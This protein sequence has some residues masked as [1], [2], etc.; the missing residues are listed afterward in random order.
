MKIKVEKNYLLKHLKMVGKALP[1]KTPLQ[2]LEGIL[3]ELTDEQLQLKASDSNLTIEVKVPFEKDGERKIEVESTGGF[4]VTGKKMIEIISKAKDGFITLELTEKGLK[5]QS[6]RSRSILPVFPSSDYPHISVSDVSTTY[7]IHSNEL[8]EII[9]TVGPFTGVNESRPV[10]MGIYF[11]F[12]NQTLMA[13]ATD[14][15]RLSKKVIPME[16]ASERFGMVLPYKGLKEVLKLVESI[17]E[18]LV[19][20]ASLNQCLIE[21]EEFSVLVRLLDGIYP[22]TKEFVPTTFQYTCEVDRKEFIGALERAVLFSTDAG[23]RVV[24][25]HFSKDSDALML[26]CLGN[27]YGEF[28]E[29]LPLNKVADFDLI[30]GAGINYLQDSLNTLTEEKVALNFN[31]PQTPFV[32]NHPNEFDSIRLVVPVRLS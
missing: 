30:V 12:E 1:V 23:N 19:L 27:G 26:K 3:F 22:E 13:C 6:G 11:C 7:S 16:S 2:A 28:E 20:K 17:D 18:E 21:A 14:S 4:I 8:A 24:E 10:L 31:G 29:E 9:R 5:I 25:L 15:F 32:I